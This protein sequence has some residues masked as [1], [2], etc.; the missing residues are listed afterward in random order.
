[1][2]CKINKKTPLAHEISLCMYRMLYKQFQESETVDCI[3]E[4]FF[5]I[6]T[7]V[8]LVGLHTCPGK[9]IKNKTKQPKT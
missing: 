6:L 1:M 9:I 2:F 7:S 3:E 4:T 8:C 5:L